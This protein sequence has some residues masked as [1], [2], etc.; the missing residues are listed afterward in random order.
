MSRQL[1]FTA[2]LM[3]QDFE[4]LF[5]Q[6]PGPLLVLQDDRCLF[7]NPALNALLEEAKDKDWRG[8]HWEALVQPESFQCLRHKF[9]SLAKHQ[10]I[11]GDRQLAPFDLTLL[12]AGQ[13]AIKAEASLSQCRLA[14]G[15]A[16]LLQLYDRSGLELRRA[17]MEQQVNRD[18]LTG[19]PNRSLFYDRLRQE[20]A[21]AQR[22]RHQLLLLFID[23]DHFKWVNDSLGHAAGDEVLIQVG[24]RLAGCIRQSDTLARLG[25]DEFTII[26]PRLHKGQQAERVVRT[27]LDALK[28]PF[29]I[30]DTLV[31]IGGS[32]GIALYP[33]DAQTLDDLINRADTAMYRAKNE[34]RSCYQYFTQE[35]HAEAVQRMQLEKD[36]LRALER[37]Q[38]RVHYQPIIELASGRLVGLES[39]IRWQ[40]P[41][42][43]LL[44][45]R[46]F[47]DVAE[48]IGL[49]RDFGLWLSREACTQAQQWRSSLQL[50]QLKISINLSCRHCRHL[51]SPEYLGQ[52]LAET[53]LPARNLVLEITENIINSKNTNAIAHLEA[54]KALG[55][56]LWLDDFGTG[57]S[58][59]SLLKRLPIDGVKVD[60]VFISSLD[61][62]PG[63][64]DQAQAVLGLMQS[65]GLRLIAEGVETVAQRDF[66]RQ[67]GCELAQGYLYAHPMSAEDFESWAKDH[68]STVVS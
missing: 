24:Q 18:S 57:Q 62:E 61:T 55:V 35:L 28:Q 48:E 32:I 47:L 10:Q 42:L 25:G 15:P 52:L 4:Q 37:D 1:D 44:P 60:Q 8:Q 31:E 27:L 66:L 36:L 26:L 20:L 17:L 67:H 22:D 11:G 68:L 65:F 19:L 45:P 12:G 38:L 3:Q 54:L 63:G 23:L 56:C 58:S 5:L 43:G 59:L 50:E 9:Q 7:A 14:S 33:D 34:G 16:I 64:L 21:H 53:G 49:A 40:H 39:L 29:S 2:H 46:L 51:L 6:F 41:E 13:R 30:G